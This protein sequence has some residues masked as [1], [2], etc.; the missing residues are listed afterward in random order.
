MIHLS[1]HLC[2][3]GWEVKRQHGL[4]AGGRELQAVQAVVGGAFCS[5]GLQDALKM[6]T[7]SV[8]VVTQSSGW[9]SY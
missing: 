3:Q 7:K 8:H 6:V 4:R 9:T 1:L 2:G 5:L